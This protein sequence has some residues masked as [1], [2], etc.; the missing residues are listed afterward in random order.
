MSELIRIGQQYKVKADKLLKRTGLIKDLKKF[1]EVHLVGAYSLGL[2]MHGDID[3]EVTRTKKYSRHEVL[4]IFNKLYLQNKFISYFIGGKWYDPR[5]GKEFPNGHYLGMKTRVNGETWT[6][7][8]WF[9]D[10][11]EYIKR[12][13]K[14]GFFW[15]NISDQQ[16]ELILT[17]KK[18]RNDQK[19]KIAG[20][21]IYEL[22]LKN[23][24]KNLKGFKDYLNSI[25]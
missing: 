24:I 17:L 9:M 1:G 10:K 25:K 19:I 22:V 6:I 21:K 5:I 13:K 14:C 12:A 20:F 2:M 23:K 11:N 8:V 7:D 15:K 3:L 4:R 16:R 18:F